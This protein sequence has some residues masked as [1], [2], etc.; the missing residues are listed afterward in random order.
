MDLLKGWSR[1]RQGLSQSDENG[2]TDPNV[3]RLFD[4]PLMMFLQT[5]KPNYGP[6]PTDRPH[7]VKL[8]AIY[9]FAFGTT[10]GVNENLQ[11]GIPVTRE[12][13][14][15]PPNNYPVQYLGRGSDG[16][17]DPFVQTDVYA[18]HEIKLGGRA[19]QL[20]LTVLNLFNTRN[21]NNVFSTVNRQNGI[22]F[23]EAQFY[24]SG[25]NFDALATAQGIPLDPRF[26][27]NSGLQAPIQARF[28][29]KLVF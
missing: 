14:V 25:L 27:Q 11:S 4:Y 5:G 21:A 10:V 2:R 12:L 16:R 18:Q 1:T 24:T 3:G 20:N 26:R 23:N 8:Q 22:T 29:V 15:L 9:Q 6:L 17:T 7:Q 13:A 19:V 28:G